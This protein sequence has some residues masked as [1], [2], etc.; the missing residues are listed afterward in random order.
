MPQKNNPLTGTQGEDVKR[1][2]D[3]LRKLG[4]RIKDKSGV[5]GEATK[6]AV[7]AYQK[8]THVTATGIADSETVDAIK[9][10]VDSLAFV[11]KGVVTSRFRAGVGG[12]QVEIVDKNVGGD[13]HLAEAATGDYGNYTIAFELSARQ[14]RAKQQPDLQA[15]VFANGALLGASDVKYNASNH[16]TLNIL[17]TEKA[18]SAL[19]SEYET[20]TSALSTHFRGNLRDLR[21]KDD[22]EDI[23]YLANKTGW[24]ARAVAMAA[25]ADQ[26]GASTTEAK[27]NAKI[28]PAFFYALFRSGLPANQ[29]TLFQTDSRTISA[30]WTQSI[31]QGVIPAALEKE[32]PGA[33]QHF[34]NL[35]AQHAIDGPRA[36]SGQLQAD[37]KT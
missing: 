11:I 1:L 20:L 37:K 24:D 27:T 3:D 4:F 31:K 14:R 9:K 5:F 18:S 10:G 34:Q 6:R 16:E 22:R 35:A 21:E 17:L 33:L 30:I 26:F 28:E 12:L 15:R 36:R 7:T 13:I 2:Q 19:P 8:K 32:V 29:N 23:T 25:L